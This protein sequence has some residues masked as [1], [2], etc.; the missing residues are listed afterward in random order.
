MDLIELQLFKNGRTH[1]S[2]YPPT[3]DLR[4]IDETTHHILSLLKEGKE[5]QEILE[6]YIEK[7]KILSSIQFLSM[8]DKKA[9]VKSVESGNR[10]I[11]DR[12]TL[13]IANDCNLR[14]RYCFAGGGNYGQARD[15]MG[16]QTAEEF[17]DFCINN[18]ERVKKII[19]FG[20]EPMLNVEVMEIVCN[21]FRYYKEKGKIAYLPKFVIIT[22][23]TILT[24]SIIDF[25]KKNIFSITVSIDGLQKINDTNRIYQN[26]KGSYEKIAQFI[27]TI[28]R[29]CNVRVQYEATFTQSH[30]DNH[31]TYE[32]I[33]KSLKNEFGIEGV[34]VNEKG[35][36]IKHLLDFWN[37]V[38]Y[39]YLQRTA[40]KYL[41]ED[42]WRI[43]YC[44]ANNRTNNMCYIIDKSFAV[45]SSGAIYA[46]QMINGIEEC[47][48]GN[49]DGMNIYNSPTLYKPLDSEVN[50]KDNEI[51]RKCWA[52]RLCGGCTVQKFFDNKLNNFAIVPNLD[53]CKTIRLCIE[54]MLLVIAYI[55][56]DAKLWSIAVQKMKEY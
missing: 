50:F 4:I 6:S 27:H 29:E 32:D 20:G 19:F 28:L 17:V 43:L 33:A 53:I 1:I 8:L 15:L 7:E 44:I 36:G 38:D 11:I 24:H 42:F 34:I 14:C 21:R 54:R 37:S 16:K 45:G 52:Q 46:C 12:I 23:G 56:K 2:Y 3:A 5:I 39:E 47:R 9:T 22:N 55:Y 10:K 41:S 31:Y 25:I 30:I 49:I 40:L 13:H 18:F 48:L 51:C 26:G 35:L